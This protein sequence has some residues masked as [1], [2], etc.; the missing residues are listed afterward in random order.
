MIDIDMMHACACRWLGPYLLFN[1]FPLFC[2]LLAHAARRE[3][4]RDSPAQHQTCGDT[5]A[6]EV[7]R[8][9][10]YLVLKCA[11]ADIILPCRQSIVIRESSMPG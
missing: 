1:C 5:K 10:N 11:D 8:L 4:V 2:S 7:H 9:H 3:A 6:D